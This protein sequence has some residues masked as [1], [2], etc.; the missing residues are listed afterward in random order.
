M[1]NQT[2]ETKIGSNNGKFQV[3]LDVIHMYPHVHTIYCPQKAAREKQNKIDRVRLKQAESESELTN[4]IKHAV[5]CIITDK[6]GRIV[7]TGRN[8]TPEGIE[9]CSEHFRSDMM[10]IERLKFNIKHSIGS[11]NATQSAELEKI[12][13][14]HHE[15]SAANEIHAEI[16]A[17]I[18]S[19]PE[20]RAGGTLYVNLQPCPVCAKVIANSGVSRVVFGKMYERSDSAATQAMFDAKNI[21]YIFIPNLLD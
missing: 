20:K 6:H 18:H 5:G 14:E 2:N 21:E 8:G 19:S 15:W 4:C 9:N 12:Y 10:R 1:C 11:V 3:D 7:S 13:L 16:N 17:I